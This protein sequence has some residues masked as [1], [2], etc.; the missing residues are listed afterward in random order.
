M[1]KVPGAP[2]F[3][4]GEPIPAGTRVDARIA[5]RDEAVCCHGCKA[6]AEFIAGA[7]LEDYYRFRTASAA[8]VDETPRADRWDAYDR[9]ELVERLW[10]ANADGT[11][12]V[13]V[14]LEG[15][16]CAACS[17][18][19]D[20]AIRANPGVCD[21][22]VNPATARAHLR[23]DPARVRL[24]ELL[25]ALERVGLRPHPLAGE[26]AE[27]LATLE[28]RAALKRLAV[29]GFGMMQVM[30]FALPLYAGGM[31]H[32]MA[33][34]FR[35]VSLI[36]SVPVAFYAGWP[37]Y[38]GA[39]QAVRARTVSMDVPVTVGIVSAFVASAWNA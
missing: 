31:D 27:Q 5:N 32:G 23:W 20:R 25:R 24:G 4:C 22:S 12:S 37:F 7:G 33:E 18:L 17:W 21:V 2:C 13:T 8:R 29:A 35:L 26:H 19:A 14:L 39:W 10:T 9:P 3:H 11:R 28:R 34:F 30:M 1:S 16:R 6:V 38:V 36:I 15:L